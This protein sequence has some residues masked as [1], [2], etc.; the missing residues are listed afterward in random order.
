[1]EELER[2]L[3]LD[4]EPAA[5]CGAV[6][7][8][9]VEDLDVARRAQVLAQVREVHAEVREIR[10]DRERPVRDDEIARRLALRVA[11]PEH[12]RERDVLIVTLVVE[13]TE[14]DRIAV[15]V[16]QR[17]GL[18]GETRL[19]AL[20]LVVTEHVGLERALTRFGAR[21]LVVGDAL[22]R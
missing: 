12:L 21:G 15:V 9:R 10:R 8:E 17:D 14:D 19:A 1:A 18:R 3:V 16:A 13:V 6:R 4:A 7:R 5:K 22:R 2:L 11:Y 20:G